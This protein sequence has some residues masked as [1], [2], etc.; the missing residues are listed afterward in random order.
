LT[1]AREGDSVVLNTPAGID[2]LTILAVSYPE[3]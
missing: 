2:E 3:K 1:K